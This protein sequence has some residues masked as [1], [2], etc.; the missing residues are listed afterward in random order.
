MSYLE[1]ALPLVLFL[2]VVGLI[3]VWQNRR[4]GYKPWLIT[5]SILCLFLLSFNPVAWLLARPLEIWYDQ[6]PIPAGIADA[7]VVPAGAVASPSPRQP[8]VLIGRDTYIRLHH[9][10]WLFKNWKPLPILVCGGG[11][12]SRSYSEATRHVLQGAGIPPELIWIEA[13]SRSTYEN[14]LYGSRILQHHGIS[15]IAL[16]I[17][18]RSTPRAVAAFRKQGMTVVPAPFRFYNLE[19]ELQDILP[20]WRAIEANG[21]TA[22]ELA[23]LLWYRLRGWI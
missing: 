13:G 4:D 17:D 8:Y 5:A 19:L 9:A 15:R 21:E 3:R 16:V 1:P 2:T 22:H 14:A 18:A 12:D 23:G 10:A 20:T 6:N 11:D 7:I